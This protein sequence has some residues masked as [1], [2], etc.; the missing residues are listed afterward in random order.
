MSVTITKNT[1]KLF[2]RRK[3]SISFLQIFS[4]I[5]ISILLVSICNCFF[6]KKV[7]LLK[8]IKMREI[9]IRFSFVASCEPFFSSFSNN[10]K[11]IMPALIFMA[12]P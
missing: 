1:S 6:Y 2:T 12:G 11:H 3:Q 5:R 7:D 4:T 10:V 9:E 8:I